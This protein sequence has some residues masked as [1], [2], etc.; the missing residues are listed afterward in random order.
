MAE[1][2]KKPQSHD[3]PKQGDYDILAQQLAAKGWS[4]AD[5]QTFIDAR[6]LARAKPERVCQMV[7][8]WFSAQLA[9][10]DEA[11][12]IRLLVETLKPVVA[13]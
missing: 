7:Q 12:Q 13:G 11:T 9:V 3:S 8:D 6:A 4:T 1:G 2:R 10:K 5:L